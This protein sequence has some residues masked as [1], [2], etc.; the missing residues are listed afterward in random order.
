VTKPMRLRDFQDDAPPR[1]IPPYT[2]DDHVMLR[3][4][5]H[6]ART[7]ELTRLQYIEALRSADLLRFAEGMTV[8]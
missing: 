2:L 8:R 1:V 7:G 4:L 3:D 6:K 5:A